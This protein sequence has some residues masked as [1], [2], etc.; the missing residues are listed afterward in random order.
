MLDERGQYIAG[1]FAFLFDHNDRF[2]LLEERADTRKYMFDLPGGDLAAL[3]R[4]EERP[5]ARGVR[6]DRYRDRRHLAPLP[7]EVSTG[8]RADNRFSWRST[9]RG[10]ARATSDCRRST[11]ATD[12]S[13]GRNTIART[14]RSRWPTTTRVD[15]WTLIAAMAPKLYESDTW[16]GMHCYEVTSRLPAAFHATTAW[17]IT[18]YMPFVP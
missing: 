16:S 9:S 11:S 8:M 17:Q 6:G 2:L 7:S 10:R 14:T 1:A 3:R 13:P 5:S 18:C 12:G 15:C 4:A